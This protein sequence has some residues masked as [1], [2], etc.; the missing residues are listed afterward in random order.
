MYKDI[1]KL[2]GILDYKGLELD[3]VAH[4]NGD[5]LTITIATE[6]CAELVQALTKVKRYGLQGDYKDNLNEE[7]A[8]VL[9]CI[10]ELIALG[11]IDLNRLKEWHNYKVDREIIRARRRKEQKNENS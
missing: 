11:Y 4:V 10:K 3:D 8:D 5:D 1:N 7:V 6:E 9:I 2:K